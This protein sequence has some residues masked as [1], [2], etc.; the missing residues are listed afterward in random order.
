MVFLDNA[1]LL[2]VKNTIDNPVFAPNARESGTLII[3]MARF[4]VD[5]F[6]LDVG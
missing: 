5:V 1:L 6:K 3:H 2:R 4:I